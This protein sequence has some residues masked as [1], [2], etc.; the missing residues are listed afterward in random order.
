MFTAI[1][2]KAASA[3][4]VFA[5]AAAAGAPAARAQEPGANQ[6]V[7][8]QDM[9]SPDTRDVAEGYGPTL[10]ADP[11][12]ASGGFDWVSAALGAAA[13]TGLMIVALTLAGTRRG[14]VQ[15]V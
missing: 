2:I 4:V 15:R 9:R 7:V 5:I 14:H 1:R 11:I 8:G 3:L 12:D 10:E 6:T 13:G